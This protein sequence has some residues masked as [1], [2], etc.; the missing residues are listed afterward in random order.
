MMPAVTPALPLV[1][2]VAI[3]HN[4]APFLCEALDSILAQTYS[5]VEVLLVDNASTD[6]S[7][8]ILQEYAVRNPSWQLQLHP[9]NIGLCRAFNEAYRSA[10][11]EFLIDFATDDV[12]LPDRIAQQVTFFQQLPA[13][14]GMVYS[15]AEL[16][17]E[18]GRHVRYHIRQRNGKLFP[19][20]ASGWVFAVVLRRY[21]ISTPTMMMRRATLDELHGYDETL[22]YEDF[23]FWVRASRHWQFYFLD[24]VTTRKR[25][26]D[27][28][29]SRG[30]YRPG[31]PHLRS[32]LAICH[33][34]W[35][36]CQTEEE[37][38]A[39]ATR[40]RWEMR[41]AARWGSY[42]A[43]AAY[44]ALLQQTGRATV[45]DQMVGRA[46]RLLSRF[47]GKIW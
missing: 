23:D 17:D 12:L 6:G 16:I 46:A 32:T 8:A 27:Q 21:F 9:Q 18:Q 24:A 11:G 1:T 30:A 36:L 2:I 34:A 43:A 7:A 19:A 25:Q 42:G 29:M 14:A 15:N 47:Q 37:R 28:A 40:V 33:K 5:Q 26:H 41:Q 39:L 10:K 3:C 20:P 31:D 4:H 35:N 45:L 38:D 44:F 13:T 22:Y